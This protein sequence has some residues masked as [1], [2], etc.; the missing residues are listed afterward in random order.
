MSV[1]LPAVIW[2]SIICALACSRQQQKGHQRPELLVRL[3][4]EST[5]ERRIPS[6]EGQ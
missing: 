6:T 4:K 1:M 5:D 2:N 3:W